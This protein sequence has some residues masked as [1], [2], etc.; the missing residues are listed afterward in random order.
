M[1]RKPS[2]WRSISSSR[3][4]MKATRHRCVRYEGFRGSITGTFIRLIHNIPHGSP[5]ALTCVIFVEY[6]MS[7]Q[8]ENSAA[9][10]L[11]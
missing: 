2:K 11:I 3:L 8:T 7:C 6:L 5:L 1:S 4:S 10:H 9:I